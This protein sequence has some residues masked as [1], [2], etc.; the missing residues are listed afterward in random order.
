MGAVGPTG[1]QDLPWAHV[2][3]AWVKTFAGLEGLA[4]AEFVFEPLLLPGLLQTEEY[5]EAITQ[6]T[7]FVRADHAERFVSFRLARARRLTEAEPLRLHAVI[8][9][10]ALRLRVGSPEL[11]RAQ[12]EHLAKLAEQPNVTIQVLRPEDGPHAA[13]TGQF[14]VLEFADVRPI[15][16]AELFD[17]AVYV[18]DPDSVRTYTM[19]AENLR[20]VALGPAESLALIQ[21]LVDSRQ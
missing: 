4:E 9:E 14:I 2:V 5:A 17:G 16:Y 20:Q 11:H 18:Q 15:A 8:G 10:S 6:S 19:V 7:G 13:V 1:F 12:L 21:S 3:P